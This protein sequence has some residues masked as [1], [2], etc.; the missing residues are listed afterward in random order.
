MAFSSR[1]IAS[2]RSDEMGCC[3][4][5]CCCCGHRLFCR[6][7]KGSGQFSAVVNGNFSALSAPSFC[8]ISTPDFFVSPPAQ[9][10]SSLF[11]LAEFSDR[12]KKKKK[13]K[14]NKKNKKVIQYYPPS[15]PTTQDAPVTPQWAFANR[16]IYPPLIV[17]FF[18]LF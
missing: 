8:M 15:P 12:K 14:N 3:C 10:P 2:V 6:S 4:C 16:K 9:R 1:S 18:F 11:A 5:C 13:K 7:T 17:Y